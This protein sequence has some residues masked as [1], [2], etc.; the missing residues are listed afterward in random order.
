MLCIRAAAT[1][2]SRATAVLVELVGLILLLGFGVNQEQMPLRVKWCKADQR[3]KLR[4][5]EV[6]ESCSF[7]FI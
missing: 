1:G 5:L 6:A 4:T 2:Q 7:T 3:G